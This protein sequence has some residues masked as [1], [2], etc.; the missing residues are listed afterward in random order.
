MIFDNWEHVLPGA[1]LLSDILETAPHIKLVAT[2]RERLNLRLETVYY[3]QPVVEDADRLFIETAQRMHGN[4]QI[5]QDDLPHVARIIQ[6]VGGMPLGLMLA[7]TWVDVLSIEDIAD[8]IA[9]SIAFLSADLG[10]IP[11]RQRSV[12][13]VID[14]TWKRISGDEK[15]AFMWASLFRGGFTHQMFQQITSTSVR[16]LQTLMQRSLLMS[17]Y[18]RRYDMHPLLRQYAH[19]KMTEMRL[20][21]EAHADHLKVF[22]AYARKWHLAMFDGQYLEALK[23]LETEQEN[24]RAVMDWALSGQDIATGT[25]FVLDMV[26]FWEVRSQAYEAEQ[27]LTQVINA[28]VEGSLLA[29]ALNWRCRYRYRL[30]MTDASQEDGWRA[31]TL[32]EQHNDQKTLIRSLI[33][34][35]YQLGLTQ[36]KLLLERALAI[37]ETLG[38]QRLLALAL[39]NVSNYY[40]NLR[41]YQQALDYLERS[42]IAYEQVGDLRGI[43]MVLYNIGII[44][45][46]QRNTARAR[47]CYEQS[48]QLKRALGDRAGTAR[49]LAAIAYQMILEEEFEQAEAN[50]AESIQLCEETGDR[51]R[52]SFALQMSAIIDYIST[53]FEAARVTLIKALGVIAEMRQKHRDVELHNLLTVVY[54]T[55]NKLELAK[56][57]A[58]YALDAALQ[59][60]RPYTDW[61]GLSSAAVY[62][63]ATQNMDLCVRISAV[64]DRE[65]K[66]GSQ[67]DVRYILNPHLYRLKAAIGEDVW[68]TAQVDN[69]SVEIVN[70]FSEVANFFPTI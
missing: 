38:D 39:N 49:R 3:L 41:M 17:G 45:I 6:F 20:L 30:G 4:V 5:T 2:S 57:H 44:H 51:F 40:N 47:E 50:L 62:F 25:Q 66:I 64:I 14:P 8:E 46:E 12:H 27:Y 18:Q 56:V 55:Q 1:D 53:D 31:I 63:F 54:L 9:Q 23:A 13:A 67:V 43:S 70:L 35:A 24:I 16:M 7:A 68:K 36:R 22:A 32:A 28:E 26:D 33:G 42:K 37:A 19:E 21:Q 11:A 29:Q 10:D 61:L 65:R 59:A 34:V 60:Q 58:K 52:L 69:Q 15:R 48:L